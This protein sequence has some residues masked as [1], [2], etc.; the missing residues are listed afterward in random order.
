MKELF[1]VVTLPHG[2][3]ARPAA[4]LAEIASDASSLVT[5]TKG[6]RSCNAKNVL[7]ILKLDVMKDQ[8]ITISIEGEDE[9]KIAEQIDALMMN[10]PV[11]KLDGTKIFRI[12]FF[13]TK[14]YDREFFAPL[15]HEKGDATYNSHIHFFEPRLT[16]ETAALADGYDAVCIFVNDD[17][18]AKVIEILEECGVRLILLRCAGFNNVDLHAAKQY[19]MTVLRVPAYSPYAVAEHAMAILQAANRRLHKASGRVKDNNFA[20]SGLI[21]LDLHNKVAGILGTGKIGQ[22]FARICKGYGMT[23][24]A[25]DAY[26]NQS[27]VDEGLLTYGTLEEVLSKADLISLH[28]PLIMGEGGTYHLINKERIALM[29]DDVM[30]VNTARGGLI[31]NEALLEGIQSE[32][33]H[34]V[35]LDVYEGEDQNVY[36]DHSGDV[37]SNDITARLQFYPQV[38]LTS[39]QAFFTRE[40]LQAIASVTMENALRFQTDKAYGNTQVEA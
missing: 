25:W 35:A 1:Y 16:E 13:G 20:L 30:L 36:T 37:I 3:H 12:A 26:P 9:E 4:K 19:D 31:D 15:S 5:I 29:K 7:Q 24:I 6:D 2:L 22:C 40:A 34:A 38:L 14:E 33:F 18:N 10:H 17:C 21:G 39:H 28:A 8:K 27:L 32:K 23:V 11:E